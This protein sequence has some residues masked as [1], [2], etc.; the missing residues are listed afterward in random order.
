MKNIRSQASMEYLIVVGVALL[1]MV[2]ATYFFFSFSKNS[3]QEISASQL[4]AIGREMISTAESLYYSGEGSKATLKL[5]IPEEV[6]TAL[7]VDQRELVFN[8]S[9]TF[10]YSELVFFSRVNLTN[11]L[12]SCHEGSCELPELGEPGV[13]QIRLTALE[14]MVTIE[15]VG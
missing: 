12:Q 10:G 13:K 14:N 6:I 11:S 4:D 7:I 8:T 2:P 15:K 9:S 5:T 3:G 1:F